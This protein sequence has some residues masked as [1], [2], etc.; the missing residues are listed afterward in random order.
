MD[1][2][3]KSIVFAVLGIMLLF[4]GFF[5]AGSVIENVPA[6]KLCVIQS[7]V[8][9]KL[10][11][12]NT[13]GPKFQAFGKPTYYSRSREFSFSAKSDQGDKKDQSIPCRFNDKGKGW[14]SGVARYEMPTDPDKIKQ[15][16]VKYTSD[17]GVYN[18]LIRPTIENAIYMTGPLMSLMES[19]SAKRAMIKTYIEDQARR[20]TYKTK[21]D[22]IETVDPITN[23]KMIVT[24]V[25]IISDSK[26]LPLR[27]EKS[28]LETYGINLEYVALNK[29]GYT[30]EVENK[31]QDQQM[32]I[33]SVD[34]AIAEAK[35][36]KQ[37]AITE[38]EEGK[39]RAAKSKWNEEEIK[40]KAVVQAE[41][42]YEVASLDNNTAQ[43]KKEATIKI[44][45][46]DY[47]A[48]KL[49]MKADN[50]LQIRVDA[51]KT[52]MIAFAENLPKQK[53]VP[54]VYIAGS[55]NDESGG[56]SVSQ[57]VNLLTAKFAKDLALD[58]NFGKHGGGK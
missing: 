17:D 8:S 40:A 38:E 1:V 43:Q 37:R 16:H 57:L 14:I 23:Q 58:F 27:S 5:S 45:E 7:I 13:P 2:S 46:A 44:A 41:Q 42:R 47:E 4:A 29:I 11:V 31:I 53:L 55:G 19:S 22:E 20:G 50:A 3:I 12:Y 6:E 48:R 21:T 51:Y 9:G 35:K 36:A 28:P 26:G 49:A 32:A 10:Y 33:M 25:E 24:K 34:I 15:I 56:G 30:R 18:Q 52:V 54:D 39:A